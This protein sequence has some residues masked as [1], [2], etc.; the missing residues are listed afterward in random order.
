M[1]ENALQI[2][3]L[4]ALILLVIWLWVS[5]RR[6]SRKARAGGEFS[7][8]EV[9]LLSANEEKNYRE[10]VS[11]AQAYALYSFTK[12]RLIDII[13]TDDPENVVSINKII[14][15]HVDFLL[16]NQDFMPV[17]V[18]EIDDSSHRTAEA[19]RRDTVKDMALE[20]AGIPILRSKRIRAADLEKYLERIL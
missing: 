10:I 4:V 16:C 20:K 19:I 11:V 1:S 8:H 17:C 12:V 6:R 5:A 13:H 3:G 15:K 18:I 14:Q 9:R 7:Y 2:L